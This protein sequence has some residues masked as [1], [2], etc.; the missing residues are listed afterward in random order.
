MWVLE[1]NIRNIEIFNDT[2]YFSAASSAF[3]DLGV[4]KLSNGLP[5]S[6]TNQPFEAVVTYVSSI[7]TAGPYGFSISPD[8]CTLYIADEGSTGA[9][10]Y[11][12]ISKWVRS[13]AIY[14]YAYS[15]LDVDPGR[16][17]EDVRLSVCF[18][19]ATIFFNFLEFSKR[20]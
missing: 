14:N 10:S 1:G 13:G 16:W 3:G 11:P 7:T 9:G 20:F 6:G 17:V 12:G 8:G 19:L 18:I 15:S 2:L 5:I 4:Y